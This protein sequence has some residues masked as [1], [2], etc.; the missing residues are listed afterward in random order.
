[1]SKNHVEN[2]VLK[3]LEGKEYVADE[4]GRIVIDDPEMVDLIKGSL[5]GAPGEV[6][7]A[8]WNGACSNGHC[9]I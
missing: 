5:G 7:E 3:M 9:L 6:S 4:F 8:L 2:D 1:M